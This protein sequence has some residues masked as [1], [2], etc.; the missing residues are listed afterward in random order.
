MNLLFDHYNYWIVI[1]LMMSGFYIVISANNL[2]K[3][4]VGLNVFQTSVFM[5]YISMGKVSGGS[6]PIVAEGIEVYSNPLPHVLIL[7]AIVVG[8]ATTSVGL[9]LI[10]RIKRAYGTVEENEFQDKDDVI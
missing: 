1:F 5:L 2:V 8:V 7:T 10:V 3:K 6:A 4:V 9:S